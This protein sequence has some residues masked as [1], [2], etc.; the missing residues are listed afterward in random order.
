LQATSAAPSEIYAI[1]RVS[2]LD[3]L[4]DGA[5]H[6]PAWR[7]YLDPYSCGEDGVLTFFAPT[8][9]VTASR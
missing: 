1:I 6:E 7:V 4:E 2:G 8:Y 5:S 9:A 3:A